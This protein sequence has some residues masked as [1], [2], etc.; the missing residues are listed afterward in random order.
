M[1]RPILTDKK[2]KKES[3]KN[4]NVLPHFCSPFCPTDLPRTTERRNRR[5]NRGKTL[6]EFI[7]NVRI[8]FNAYWS[9]MNPNQE[10]DNRKAAAREQWNAH[11]EKHKAIMEWLAKH[12]SYPNRNPYYFIH[13]F[14]LPKVK[15]EIRPEPT[16]YQGKAI[17]SGV[18]VLSAKY[19]GE[20][21][22]YTQDD[23]DSFHMEVYHES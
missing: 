17:P 12:G 10:Y 23:I 3:K 1:Y 6:K 16:N 2:K 22:M 19:K 20:W 5:Q 4:K 18:I 14:T 13:D 11:P 8:D 15:A 7:M 21:G 9:A